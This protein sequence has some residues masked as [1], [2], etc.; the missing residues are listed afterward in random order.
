MP[1][2]VQVGIDTGGTFTDFVV[3]EDGKLTV[4]KV[5]STPRNPEQ[6]ILAGLRELELDGEPLIIHGTTVATNALLERKGASTALI[7]NTHFANIIDI[8][9]Q[10]RQSLYSLQ[11]KVSKPL[12]PYEL[13]FTVER[14]FKDSNY[15][16]DA[17]LTILIANLL[18]HNPESLA[19]CLLSAYADASLEK[20]IEQRLRAKLPPNIHIT[21]SSDLLS[22]HREYERMATTVLNAYVTPIMDEYISH[23]EQ[24]LPGQPIQIMQS[25][26]GLISTTTASTQAVRTILSGPAG[27]AVGALQLGQLAGY[28]NLITFDMGGTSTDVSLLPGTLTYTRTT[29]VEGMPLCLPMLAI[30]T[31]GA[32]GGSIVWLDG[33]GVLRVGPQ[34]AG[35]DPGPAAYGQSTI[36]TT[37]DANLVLGRILPKYFF[38]GRSILYPER[39]IDAFTQLASALS[40]SSLTPQQMAW[41]T[42]QVAN[43]IMTRAIRRISVEKGYDPRDFT[44][45]PFG[46]A[47]PLHACDLADTLQIPRILIPLTPGVLSAY[48]MV[49][50]EPMFDSSVTILRTFSRNQNIGTADVIRDAFSMLKQKTI[51]QLMPSDDDDEITIQTA[52]DMRY[53]GQSH[54]VTVRKDRN[55]SWF[56]AFD[57]EHQRLY[58]HAKQAAAVE[59]VTARVFAR[60]QKQQFELAEF[61][62]ATQPPVTTEQTSVYFDAEAPTQ[63]N[64]Y[65]RDTLLAGH[66]VRGPAIVCQLDT[67]I[68]I[69][70]HWT[71]N[72]DKWGNLILERNI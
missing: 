54:E 32:G 30:H 23:L 45:L 34:S 24:K 36:P 29:D 49:T 3:L 28:E 71:A 57:T 55:T 42:V 58:G 53:A 12:I 68:V 6:A 63:A 69:T 66:T 26:G 18:K 17:N 67:T 46:G 33:G 37:T 4:H 14:N 40:P 20:Y 10:T 50:A 13:R 43:A 27:G 15:L 25:N 22:E 5:F 8:G 48:G 44:L 35:A 39:S 38:G 2:A 19:I 41:S 11:P 56:A 62:I 59:V 72:V 21:L 60:R 7:T 1:S 64:L 9:R 65:I 47:G 51:T 61:P 70:P 31:V 52:L 16:N